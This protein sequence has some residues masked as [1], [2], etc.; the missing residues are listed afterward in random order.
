MNTE[1]NKKKICMIVQ[2]RDVKGGIASVIEGYYGSSLESD[3]DVTYIEGYCDRNKVAKIKKFLLGVGQF[4]SLLKNNPP[5]LVHIHSSFGPSFTRKRFYINKAFKVGIPIVNHIH[6]ADFD[7]FYTNASKHKKRIIRECYSKC[8]ILV[9]LSDEWKT[10]ISDIVPSEKIRVIENYSVP[11][12]T[13][14]IREHFSKRFENKQVLFLGEIG[15]RKGAYDLPSIISRVRDVVPE[16][17]FVIAGSGDIDGVKKGLRPQDM[18]SVSFPGWLRGKAKEDVLLNSS[19]FLL[20]S[21]NEGLPMSILDAMG[22]GLPIVSTNVGGIPK[23]V[24]KNS[25]G[26][27]NGILSTPGELEKMSSDIVYYLTDPNA[28]HQAEIA[29]L[30]IVNQFYSFDNHIRKLEEVYGELV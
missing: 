13:G 1:N 26:I 3:Y 14:L 15:Q 20:P 25:R 9:V 5:D 29:S 23:L 16:A 19:V 30:D 21:Y 11:Q 28:Q 4:C 2:Q 18:E 10:L 22:Y 27:S 8:S 6:G 12:D 7:S 24:L 17:K